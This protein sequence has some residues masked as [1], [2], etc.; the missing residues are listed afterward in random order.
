M[1]GSVRISSSVPCRR[2][3]AQLFMVMAGAKTSMINGKNG[4]S[5]SRLARLLTKKALLQNAAI[6]LKKTK[7]HKNT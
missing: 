2:S 4:V 5:W 3:S 6:V 7:T 1:A